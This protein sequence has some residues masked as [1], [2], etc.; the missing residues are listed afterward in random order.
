VGCLFTG[1]ILSF[2]GYYCFARQ[3]DRKVSAAAAVSGG[4]VSS[5]FPPRICAYV[6]DDSDYGNTRHGHGGGLATPRKSSACNASSPIASLFPE[7]TVLYSDMVGFTAWSA[8]RQPSQVFIASHM[9]HTGLPDQIHVSS[10]TAEYL[11]D[12]GKRSWLK[13]RMDAVAAVGKSHT[14]TTYWIRLEDDASE[15]E[16]VDFYYDQCQRVPIVS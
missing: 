1:I 13:P 12:S 9:E 16:A 5:L 11:I 4:I 10:A 6:L 14:L 15:W 2:V 3:R 8:I 7:A